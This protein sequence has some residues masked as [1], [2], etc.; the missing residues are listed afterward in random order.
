MLIYGGRYVSAPAANHNNISVLFPH[1]VSLKALIE[2][3]KKA[4][5]VPAALPAAEPA[6]PP[7]STPEK[8]KRRL[9][10]LRTAYDAGDQS[11]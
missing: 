3:R 11:F 10:A 6:P 8:P 4:S 7:T 5:A 1:Q 9:P 2:E